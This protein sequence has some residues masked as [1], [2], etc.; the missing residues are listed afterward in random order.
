MTVTHLGCKKAGSG[1]TSASSKPCYLGEGTSPLG[2]CLHTC[3]YQA[4]AFSV[5]AL[6]TFEVSGFCDGEGCPVPC[7]TFNSIRGRLPTEG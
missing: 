1:P 2:G 6:L 5:L 4:Q 7:G 3:G